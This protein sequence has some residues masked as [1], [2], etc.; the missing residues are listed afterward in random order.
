MRVDLPPVT[1]GE[2][3]AYVRPEAPGGVAAR[4][5]IIAHRTQMLDEV[6]L[7]EPSRARTSNADT[8]LGLTPSNGAIAAGFIPSTT[9]YQRA[10][11][12]R[13][14]NEAKARC[15]TSDSKAVTA[16]STASPG[17]S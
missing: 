13:S 11:C 17:F 12:Q 14:G 3:P 10:A 7:A 2:G 16:G 8:P 4:G 1:A 6:G 15:T 5:S 9:W